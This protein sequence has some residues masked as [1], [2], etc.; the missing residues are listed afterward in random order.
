MV[1]LTWG[2]S[3]SECQGL[4]ESRMLPRFVRRSASPAYIHQPA[5]IVDPSAAEIRQNDS[6]HNGQPTFGTHVLHSKAHVRSTIFRSQAKKRT[7]VQSE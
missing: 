4:Y 3:S 5:S 7:A 1:C 2:H 6:A